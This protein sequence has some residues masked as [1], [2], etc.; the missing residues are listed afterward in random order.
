MYAI[1]R[2][3]WRLLAA[4]LLFTAVNP[5]LFP[6]PETDEAWM[7]RGVLAERWWLDE[8]RGTMGLSYPNVCNTLAVPA[9]AY[10]LYAAWRRKPAEMALATA[11]SMALKLW[12]IGAITRRYDGRTGGDDG[13]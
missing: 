12:W 1:Y 3:D 11:L 13:D 2:R 8:D 7:T 10:A 4:T 9:F 6:P 5:V